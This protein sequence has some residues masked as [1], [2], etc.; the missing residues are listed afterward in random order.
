TATPGLGEATADASAF[1]PLDGGANSFA[2]SMIS[3]CRERIDRVQEESHDWRSEKF[4]HGHPINFSRHGEGYQE[5]IELTDV[6]RRQHKAA[7]GIRVF[8]PQHANTCDAAKR[9]FHEQFDGAVG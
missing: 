7:C 8:A 4:G 1:P 3:L 2:I 9:Q 5:W 6:I